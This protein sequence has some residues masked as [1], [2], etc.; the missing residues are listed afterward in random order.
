MAEHSAWI[1]LSH[2]SADIEKVRMIRNEFERL[3][4]NPL[5]FHLKCL[6]DEDEVI[7]LIKREI[8]ARDWF[9]YCQSKNA[10]KSKYVAIERAYI[11]QLGKNKVWLLDMSLDIEELRKKIAVICRDT[12]VFIS[13]AHKNAALGASLAKK[14][15]A[16]DYSVWLDEAVKPGSFHWAD[17]VTAAIKDTV[18]QSGYV[19]VLLTEESVEARYCQHELL[20]AIEEE[21]KLY[22]IK[23]GDFQLSAEWRFWTARYQILVYPQD[24]TVDKIANDFDRNV[25]GYTDYNKTV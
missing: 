16:M 21:A 15:G 8:E 18:A 13:Y 25:S 3:H 23:I 10:E 22:L 17:Q 9:V 14:L 7:D 2:S 11:K 1:F 20:F 4:Q 6:S 5:A 24:V 19:V 12:K